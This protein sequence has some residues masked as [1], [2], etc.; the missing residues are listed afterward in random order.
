MA[1]TIYTCNARVLFLHHFQDSEEGIVDACNKKWMS[2]KKILEDEEC[3]EIEERQ[4]V[5]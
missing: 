3:D 5:I 4:K 2:I 1:L